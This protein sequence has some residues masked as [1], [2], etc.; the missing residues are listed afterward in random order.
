MPPD[1]TVA[2]VIG[3]AIPETNSKNQFVGYVGT[4]TDITERKARKRRCTRA[5][6]AIA[7][8]FETT[9]DAILIMDYDRFIDCNLPAM[10]LFR[11]DRASVIGRPPYE[12]FSP[13][14]Q[15]DSRPSKDG[16]RWKRLR[17]RWA[18]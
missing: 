18:A 2:W 7:A 10:K 1:G 16:R 17:R 8:L 14:M 11:G 15:P 4:L 13:P 12:M 9:R 6:R 3:Q 5:R